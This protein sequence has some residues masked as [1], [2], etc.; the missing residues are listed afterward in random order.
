VTAN[1]VSRA[2]LEERVK[3]AL[4]PKAGIVAAPIVADFESLTS[5]VALKAVRSKQ[6]ERLWVSVNRT[7]H[8]QLVAV[9][10]GS[11]D[12]SVSSKNGKVTINLSQVETQVKKDLDAKGITVFD[13]VPAVKGLNFVL[14]Q[15]KSLTKV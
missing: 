5:D 11:S 8:K 15:S 7:S 10:T 12:G 1:L 13:K 6:F 3:A 14:F 4:P 2:N 9:L